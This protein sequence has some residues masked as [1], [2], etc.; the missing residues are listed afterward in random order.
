[1]LMKRCMSMRWHAL[2]M[3]MAPMTGEPLTPQQEAGIK[4]YH[5]NKKDR[6]ERNVGYKKEVIL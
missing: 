3:K 4:R 6:K 2:E 1:M 5:K